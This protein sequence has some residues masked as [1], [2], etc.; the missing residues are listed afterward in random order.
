MSLKVT[1]GYWREEVRASQEVLRPYLGEAYDDL[2][3][4]YHGGRHGRDESKG[5]D[6]PD[7]ENTGFEWIALMMGQA[8]PG[9]PQVKTSSSEAQG[10]LA[11]QSEQLEIALNELLLKSKFR[12][13]CCK[14]FVDYSMRWGVGLVKPIPQLGAYQFQDPPRWPQAMRV[15]IRD[16]FF[17]PRALDADT[18]RWQGHRVRADKEDILEDAKENPDLGWNVALLERLTTITEAEED[19]GGANAAR[20]QIRWGGGPDRQQVEYVEVWIPELEL[21]FTEKDRKRLGGAR[22]WR[23]AGYNGLILTVPLDYEPGVP[24]GEDEDWIREPRPF[25]GPSSGPYEFFHA[26]YV[27]DDSAPLSPLG[28]VENQSE[29]LN[30]LAK[31]MIR[32]A[33]N[34]KRLVIVGSEDPE[35]PIKVEEGEHD[36]IFT[37]NATDVRRSIQQVELGGTSNEQIVATDI[38]KNRHQRASGL[39]DAQ[40]GNVTGEGTATEVLA[41]TQAS[42][43]RVGLILNDFR[44]GMLGLIYKMAWYVWNDHQFQI[45]TGSQNASRLR[46]SST[47][48]PLRFPVIRG[49][50]VEVGPEGQEAAQPMAPNLDAVSISLHTFNVQPFG[51]T[52][53]QQQLLEFDQTAMAYMPLISD[54]RFLHVDW[55]KFFA[56]RRRLVQGPDFATC[57]D[58]E[59]ARKIAAAMLQME[60][61]GG[62]KADGP[63]SPMFSGGHSPNGGGP[64]WRVGMK[65][66]PQHSEYA[67][68]G[69]LSPGKNTAKGQQAKQ[70]QKNEEG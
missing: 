17:D 32:S 54:P 27:P 34:W 25:W 59:E 21:E 52:S 50:S 45:Q 33:R 53:P 28:A 15:S 70:S 64:A 41:A 58:F 43:A 12:R 66:G 37:T 57:V 65:D 13:E 42:A 24:E 47:G 38:A 8:I 7:P 6:E 60:L 55:A 68:G 69:L 14:L 30:D 5:D 3:R 67:R 4:N 46:H 40:R 19:Q 31:A 36:S 49:G 44:E 10:E 26:Y 20:P 35:L 48:E 62:P 18:W 56:D 9:I 11:E 16:F 63:P 29:Y 51:T 2:I 1:P 39:D 61:E 23:E 22:S